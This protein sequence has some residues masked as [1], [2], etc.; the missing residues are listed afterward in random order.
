MMLVKELDR[1][2]HELRGAEPQTDQAPVDV[3]GCSW[4]TGSTT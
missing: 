2:R 4:I 1:V 3:T